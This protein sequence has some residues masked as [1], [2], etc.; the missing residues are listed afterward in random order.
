MSEEQKKRG[1]PVIGGEPKIARIEGRVTN[2]T[3][4]KFEY[5]C[6]S[7]G[8]SKT[9]ALEYLINNQY[10]FEVFVSNDD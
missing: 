8:L 3:L 9:A 6:K 2:T 4:S 1:R 5:I 10:N 7:R